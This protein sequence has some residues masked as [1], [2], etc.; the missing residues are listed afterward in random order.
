MLT[1]AVATG[2]AAFLVSQQGGSHVGAVSV[3]G[4]PETGNGNHESRFLKEVY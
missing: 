2:G 4:L 3:V 1:G